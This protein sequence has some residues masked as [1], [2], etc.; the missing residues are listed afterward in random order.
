MEPTTRTAGDTCTCGN[1]LPWHLIGLTESDGP[2]FSHVCS[3]GTTWVAKDSETVEARPSTEEEA[4]F[5]KAAM[6]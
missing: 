3:C 5:S 2:S 1:R 6:R 4:R